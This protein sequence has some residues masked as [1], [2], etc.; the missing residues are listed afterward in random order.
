MKANDFYAE[1]IDQ[2]D[3][4]RK[5]FDDYFKLTNP[6]K[7]EMHNLE[8]EALQ[9]YENKNSTKGVLE[10]FDRQLLKNQRDVDDSKVELENLI[11]AQARRQYQIQKLSELPVPIES[12]IAYIVPDYHYQHSDIRKPDEKRIQSKKSNILSKEKF[13]TSTAK[14]SSHFS[15]IARSGE[16]MKLEVSLA[17]ETRRL[18]SIINKFII[19]T[20]EVESGMKTLASSTKKSLEDDRKEVSKVI[21]ENDSLDFKCYL[22]ISE[23]LRLRLQIMIVQREEVE[24]LERLQANKQAFEKNEQQTRFQLTSDIEMMNARLEAEL[25]AS[26]NEFE[27]QM[28][29]LDIQIDVAKHEE[30]TYVDEGSIVKGKITRLQ[31][32][33]LKEQARVDKLRRRHLLEMEGYQ[34]EAKNLRKRLAQ[35]S[36]LYE[37]RQQ[38]QLQSKS[39]LYF[40]M[41]RELLGFD[42]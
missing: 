7:G 10:Q 18:S 20:A 9:E 26:A 24:E 27:S 21:E 6:S 12:D 33:L 36:K 29:S 19:E 25:V 11:E 5:L 3:G 15:K 31:N 2:F 4:E 28:H 13:S 37:S 40:N 35:V 23:L 34:T 14:P 16:V 8:W 39:K 41:K 30:K 22:S 32:D 17:N 38:Q 42:D 1:R